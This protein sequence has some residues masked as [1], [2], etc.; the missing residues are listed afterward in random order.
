M[1]TGH[2]LWKTLTF[3]AALR[4]D[5]ID[6]PFVLDGA[7]N[8]KAFLVDVQDVLGPTLTTGDLV[9]TDNLSAHKVKGVREVIEAAGASLLYLPPYSPG[10]NPIEMM[11]A[12]L[13]ALLRKAAERTVT[14]FGDASE[15]S[16]TSSQ[17]KSASTIS[18]R[19]D[20]N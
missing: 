14:D 2:G 12:K 13:K 5:R 1:G 4:A 16:S 8:R 15:D 10:L 3:V 7:M 9:I 6:A 19:P 18:K 11:F 17:P 20:M